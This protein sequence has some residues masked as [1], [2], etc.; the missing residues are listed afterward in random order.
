M[1]F[2]IIILIISVWSVSIVSMGQS[3]P[4]RDVKKDKVETQVSN[5]R[6]E[7]KKVEKQV[8]KKKIESSPKIVAVTPQSKSSSRKVVHT[9]KT[10]TYLC[11]IYSKTK[12]NDLMVT[13]DGNVVSKNSSG[14]INISLKSGYHKLSATAN[15]YKSYS[16]SIYVDRNN[17]RFEIELQSNTEN[18]T[19][20]YSGG[21]KYVGYVTNGVRNGYGTYYWNDGDKFYGRWVDGKR[22]GDGIYTWKNGDTY[23]GEWRDGKFYGNGTFHYND[24]LCV[25][26][27]FDNAGYW[28]SKNRWYEEIR[29]KNG[30]KYVGASYK[31][32]KPNGNGTYYFPNGDKFVGVWKFTFGGDFVG[33]GTYYSNNYLTSRLN[34]KRGYVN[35]SFVFFKKNKMLKRQW[36]IGAFNNE[37]HYTPPQRNVKAG[38]SAAFEGK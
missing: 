24:G 6:E 4:K 7:P 10:N 11:S 37:S 26:G 2:R 12:I 25:A 19:Q 22:N 17:T 18:V 1:N 3:K 9:N 33:Y 35:S 8:E 29:Y 28:T 36:K 34:R 15:G 27:T 32:V 38:L 23:V 31:R 21:D 30:G 20:N 14:L 5:K 13:V 16:S